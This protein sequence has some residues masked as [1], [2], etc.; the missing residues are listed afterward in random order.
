[1]QTT[2]GLVRRVCEEGPCGLKRH[3]A[4]GV[5]LVDRSRPAWQLGDIAAWPIGALASRLDLVLLIDADVFGALGRVRMYW[6][7][8]TNIDGSTRY[9]AGVV[10]R[11]AHPDQ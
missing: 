6:G 5:P 7:S 3:C 1:M 11:Y 9:L 4:A 10:D 8:G 2:T